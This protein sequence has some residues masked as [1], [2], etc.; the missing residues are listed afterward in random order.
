MKKVTTDCT[1]AGGGGGGVTAV[2]KINIRTFM[3]VTV[4]LGYCVLIRDMCANYR[5]MYA[6]SR[7][8]TFFGMCFF[9]SLLT[10]LCEE[11]YRP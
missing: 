9:S 4:H 10:T 1:D 3:I 6:E 7:E 8:L 2:Y 11:G 5:Y